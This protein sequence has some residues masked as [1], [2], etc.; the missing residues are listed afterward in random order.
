MMRPVEQQVVV[1]EHA[2]R[3]LGVDVG[4]E[5]HGAGRLPLAAPRERLI[6]HLVASDAPVFTTR[7]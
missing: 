5:Q 1:I 2:L 3:L 7:E 6:E 4:G